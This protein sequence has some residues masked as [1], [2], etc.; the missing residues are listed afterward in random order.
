MGHLECYFDCGRTFDSL[1]A[2]AL[3]IDVD[4]REDN[5]ISPFVVRESS[6]RESPVTEYYPPTA[7]SRAPPEIPQSFGEGPQSKLFPC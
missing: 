1:E 2:L 4:H 5:D 3:H 6:P 7:P